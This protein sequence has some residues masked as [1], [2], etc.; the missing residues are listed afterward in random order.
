MVS[1]IMSGHLSPGPSPGPKAERRSLTVQSSGSWA[2]EVSEMK[3][4]AFEMS[5]YLCLTT[6]QEQ[7]K[8][9]SD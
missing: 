9:L 8:P 6:E 2:A 4:D 1:A 3:S 5:S 7:E